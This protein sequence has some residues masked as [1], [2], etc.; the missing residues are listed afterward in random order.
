MKN[1]SNK[2]CVLVTGGCGYI[3]SHVTR[4]LSEAGHKVIV[5]DDL[6]TGSKAALLHDELLYVGDFGSELILRK[7]FSEHNVTTIMHFAASISVPQAAK[8]PLSYYENNTSKFVELLKHAVEAKVAHVIFSSSA[9]VYGEGQV[10]V[11][12]ES[13]PTSPANAYGR[14]KLFDEYIL[15]DLAA[16]NPLTFV[17]LRYF[18]VAGTEPGNRLGPRNP[19]A[20]HLIKI[21]C[22]TALGKRSEMSIYGTDYKTKDGTGVRDYIHVEDLASC[23]VEALEYLVGGGESRILNCGYGKGYTVREVIDEVK[24]IAKKDFKV[25][26]TTRRAGDIGQIIADPSALRELFNW[27]PRYDDLSKIIASSLE[28]E[29]RQA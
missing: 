6:S 22:Q 9:A 15:Q 12:K 23:H 1:L 14:S 28:W 3:G 21:A 10:P 17:A 18:N 2:S 11:V 24:R 7:I 16:A 27:Q 5:V 13:S 25:L 20:N 19:T 29:R 26:E 4:Q 8:D